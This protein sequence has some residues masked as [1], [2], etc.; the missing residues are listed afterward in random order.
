MTTLRQAFAGLG[1]QDH[2]GLIV[3]AIRAEY[4]SGAAP[5]SVGGSAP[6]MVVR[7]GKHADRRKRA[8]SRL[9]LYRD[10]N[11][12]AMAAL[13]ARV[14]TVNEVRQERERLVEMVGFQ[15]VPKR[16]TDEVASLYSLPAKRRFA[17]DARAQAFASVERQVDLHSVMKEASRLCFLLNN[18]LLWSYRRD[19]KPS[20]RIITPDAFDVIPNP[21]D[22]LDLVAVLVDCAPA[23]VPSTMT[24]WALLPHFE[25]WD[26]E[27][28]IRLNAHGQLIDAEPHGMGRIPGVL[29]SSR[30]PTERLL[31]DRP[32]EDIFAAA[33]SVL[34]L[35]LL[36][37]S[38]S[39]S[40]S[41]RQ[42]YFRGAIAQMAAN[43]PQHAGIPLALPPGVDVGTLDLV[44]DPDHLLKVARHVVAS[45]AQS[46]G[47]SYEQFVFSETADTAS[48]K[49]WTVRRAKLIEMRVEQRGRAVVHERGVMDLLGFGD[50]LAPDFAEQEAPTD[51][52]EELDVFDRR[53]NRGLDNPI[54]Y[55]M[56]KDTDLT[57][58]QATDRFVGNISVTAWLFSLLRVL[59]LNLGATAAQPGQ[60]PEQNGA[61]GAANPSPG[62]TGA[63]TR[64]VTEGETAAEAAATA[65]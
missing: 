1:L 8:A 63:V 56:R 34:F 60:S 25:L 39:H 42:P 44:T 53:C 51:P 15:N 64:S 46:Y 40:S 50:A 26:S 5:S 49:A 7:Q 10:D 12:A 16:I 36:L 20:L 41:E 65:A 17:D 19:D 21:K 62:A 14:Y 43:Q 52:L 27:V 31:D 38:L 3:E 54:A 58:D 32:G 48:G 23:W 47:M 59:N 6:A 13:L 24:N 35:N 28:K 9:A 22:A 11:A 37:I 33:R 2:Y 57:T 30:M 4:L 55:L 61:S 45:V 29:F 18:V